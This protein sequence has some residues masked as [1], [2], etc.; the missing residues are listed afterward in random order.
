MGKA[1]AGAWAALGMAAAPPEGA[2]RALTSPSAAGSSTT[3]LKVGSGPSGSDEIATARGGTVVERETSAGA[4]ETV[5]A[6]GT[7]SST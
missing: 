6:D 2:V 5:A 7:G 4:G 1:R 3:E